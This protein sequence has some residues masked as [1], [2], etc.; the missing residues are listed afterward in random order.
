MT[1]S[2]QS[3]NNGIIHIRK[4]VVK[5]ILLS[6]GQEGGVCAI[7]QEGGVCAIVVFVQ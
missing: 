7:G 2:G 3:E 6:I 4:V 1:D 5:K